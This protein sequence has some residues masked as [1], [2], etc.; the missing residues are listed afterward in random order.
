MAYKAKPVITVSLLPSWHEDKLQQFHARLVE[1]A[2]LVPNWGIKG[3]DDLITLFPKDLMKKGTGE[4]IHIHVD[5][6]DGV[7]AGEAST[8]ALNAVAQCLVRAVKDELPKAYVQCRVFRFNT[9]IAFA[10][11]D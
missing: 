1:A 2:T 5:L 7:M 8:P 3:E 11:S 10:S 4:E 9:D 6:P